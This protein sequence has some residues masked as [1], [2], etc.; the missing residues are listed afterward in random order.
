M[1][2]ATNNP[3]DGPNP[4]RGPNERDATLIDIAEGRLSKVEDERDID[5]T[6]LIASL[7]NLATTDRARAEGSVELLRNEA[8]M[9]VDLRN[10]GAKTPNEGMDLMEAGSVPHENILLWLDNGA[11]H[12]GDLLVAAFKGYEKD[13]VISEKIISVMKELRRQAAEE[14]D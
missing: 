1:P 9:W 11:L 14:T 3:K 6:S 4:N 8:R 5:I 13:V 2:G 12:S 10:R 7:D